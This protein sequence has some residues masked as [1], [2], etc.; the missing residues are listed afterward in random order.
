MIEAGSGRGGI[1]LERRQAGGLS[2]E[3]FH[4]NWLAGPVADELLLPTPN[5]QP[6]PPERGLLAKLSLTA[7]PRRRRRPSSR[8][9]IVSTNRTQR[10]F[11][12]VISFFLSRY[13][14]YWIA[15]ET[16]RAGP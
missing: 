1:Q 5:D 14:I 2:R 8:P 16:D 10:M 9:V 4:T 3:A 12:I 7:V 15:V 6:V 13:R 11:L